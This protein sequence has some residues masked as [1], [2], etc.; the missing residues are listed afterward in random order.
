MPDI[1]YLDV[2]PEKLAQAG[3]GF[4]ELAPQAGQIATGFDDSVTPLVPK[5]GTSSTDQA[6][7]TNVEQTYV[8]L[9]QA[10]R[11]SGS[12]LDGAGDAFQSSSGAYTTTDEGNSDMI[13]GPDDTTD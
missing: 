2:N 6:W 11:L 3:A 9:Q 13:G 7:I 12:A 10:T 1:P 8:P 5:W 4:K